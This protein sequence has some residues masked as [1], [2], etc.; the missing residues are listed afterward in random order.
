MLREEDKKENS[1][2][3]ASFIFI[4]VWI[5]AKAMLR[6]VRRSWACHWHST[7]FWSYLN[8]KNR[9]D[10]NDTVSNTRNRCNICSISLSLFYPFRSVGLCA[11]FVV[12]SHLFH[13][14]FLHK[15]LHQSGAF[16]FVFSSASFCWCSWWCCVCNSIQMFRCFLLTR[17]FRS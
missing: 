16:L 1:I 2:K 17:L 5:N 13:S 3:L 15:F 11:P 7:T 9:N 4:S 14:I 10:E 6:S 12:P 8:V